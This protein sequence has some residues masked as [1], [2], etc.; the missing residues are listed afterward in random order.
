[1]TRLL[2]ITIA[3]LA[4]TVVWLSLRGEGSARGDAKHT[5]V[6]R[7]GDVMEVEGAPIGCQVARRSGR[8]VI[9]CRRGGRLAGTYGT[10]FDE[11]RVRV[12][13]FRSSDTAKVVFKAKHRGRARRCDGGA[14]AR[15]SRE[16]TR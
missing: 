8:V 1:M 15:A 7:V 9:D 11:R 13:R 14:A 2:L 16:A 6:M 5:V 10:M 3:V 12:T 4:L